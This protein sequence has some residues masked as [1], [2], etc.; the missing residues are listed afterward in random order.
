MKQEFIYVINMALVFK[1][2]TFDN[3]VVW[4]PVFAV[5]TEK[6]ARQA[7]RD[8]Q[9]RANSD[10]FLDMYKKYYIYRKIEIF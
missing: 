9:V 1:G 6:E 5:K 3:N 7:C 8:A 4:E 10:K 2:E